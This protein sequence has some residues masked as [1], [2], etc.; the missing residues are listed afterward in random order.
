MI[1]T[2]SNCWKGTAERRNARMTTTTATSITT[3]Y[4]QQII[5]NKIVYQYNN[6]RRLIEN[7]PKFIISRTN[8]A[9]MNVS[10]NII[11]TVMVKSSETLYNK[12]IQ[13]SFYCKLKN[14]CKK[15]SVGLTDLRITLLL[16]QQNFDST[17]NKHVLHVSIL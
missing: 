17:K 16:L 15:I 4:L 1:I 11:H 14:T 3:I 10:A 6:K 8:K 13:A 2:S 9:G 7:K 5:D 12:I